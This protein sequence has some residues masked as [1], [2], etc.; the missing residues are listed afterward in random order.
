[1]FLT[2]LNKT[3]LQG[4]P[5]ALGAASVQQEPNGKMIPKSVMTHLCVGGEAK[6]VTWGAQSVGSGPHGSA[7]PGAMMRGALG[8]SAMAMLRVASMEIPA[9]SW[10]STDASDAALHGSAMTNAPAA[11]AHCISLQV[12]FLFAVPKV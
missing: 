9:W 11:D 1:M 12:A 8:T 6:L 4:L 3:P 2:L 10:G 5:L 7:A